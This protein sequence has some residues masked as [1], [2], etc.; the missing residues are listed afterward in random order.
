M[1]RQVLNGD[2]GGYVAFGLLLAFWVKA[3]TINLY[4][5]P[6]SIGTSLNR[7]KS[8]ID[9]DEEK[10]SKTTNPINS[11]TLIDCAF[12]NNQPLCRKLKPEFK[13]ITNGISVK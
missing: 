1:D 2:W 4:L 5:S 10:A 3:S 7:P 9:K 13:K 11:T 6:K 12:R 8:S